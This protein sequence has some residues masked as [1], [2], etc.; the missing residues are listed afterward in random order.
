MGNIAVFSFKHMKYSESKRS[1]ET[2]YSE[3][4]QCGIAL[5]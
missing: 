1:S 5:F 4:T 2:C 3:L